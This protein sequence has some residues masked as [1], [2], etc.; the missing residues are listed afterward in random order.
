MEFIQQVPPEI[1][2]ILGVLN[3]PVYL[4]IAWLAFDSAR[5]AGKTFSET[6]IAILK[7]IFLPPIVRVLMDIDTNDAIGIVPI[8]GF[9]IACVALVVGEVYLLSLMGWVY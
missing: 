4:F 5:G 6:I 1:W 2:V 8:F 9:F 3:I 7:I